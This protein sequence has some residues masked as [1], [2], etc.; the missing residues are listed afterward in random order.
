MTASSKKG[1]PLHSLLRLLTESRFSYFSSVRPDGR[2]HCVPIWHVVDR[3][4]IFMAVQSRS[5][6][7]ANVGS[8]P[9]VVVAA[10]LEIPEAGLIVE[11]R[12]RLRPELR[13]TVSPLF[14]AKYEWKITESE[15]YDSLIEV[16]ADRLI[17]W[18]EYGEGRWTGEQVRRAG[19]AGA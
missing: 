5:V 2:P 13:A 18:G 14:E 12:A 6:K 9:H 7:A 8:N 1:E 11:G 4:N 3:G 10:R 15:D 17:A 16:E 19:R